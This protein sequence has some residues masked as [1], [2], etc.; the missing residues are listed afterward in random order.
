MADEQQKPTAELSAFVRDALLHIAEGV[1]QANKEASQR[2]REGQK[3]LFFE[4]ERGDRGDMKGRELIEFDIAVTVTS[5]GTKGAGAGFGIGVVGA[6]IGGKIG[7]SE[8][9]Q[10]AHVSR[11]RFGV[12][13]QGH[14]GPF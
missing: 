7:S 5:K 4:I 12:Y 9:A 2:Y 1:A 3:T 14:H 13:L 6:Q 10:R 8:E 11:I